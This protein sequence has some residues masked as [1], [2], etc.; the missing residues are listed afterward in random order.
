MSDGDTV[1]VQGEVGVEVQCMVSFYS[2]LNGHKCSGS[3]LVVARAPLD[4]KNLLCP[5][6]KYRIHQN[7]RRHSQVK[8]NSYNK[9]SKKMFQK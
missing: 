8:K 6:N 5:G 9:F 4:K 2:M 1:Q 7:K 3:V